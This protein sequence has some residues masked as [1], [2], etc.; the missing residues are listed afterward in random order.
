MRFESGNNE[1]AKDRLPSTTHFIN[2][3]SFVCHGGQVLK[4]TIIKSLLVAIVAVASLGSQSVQAQGG[5]GVVAILDVA[6][7][8]E[9]NLDFKN[10]MEGIRNDAEG[11]KTEITRRQELIK[12]EAQGL[13]KFEVGSANRMTL[14][15]TLKLKQTKLQTFAQQK[16]SLLLNRE[17]RVYYETYRR[18]QGTVESLAAANN[19]SLVLR[20]ESGEINPDNRPEVIKGVNRSVVYHRSAGVDLTS[21]VSKAMN[22]SSAQAQAPA[23]TQYK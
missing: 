22:A 3:I 7:V 5:Q 12:Q 9:Q 19:I 17:A 10:K 16:E 14:E 21:L 6:L 23:Q 4:S 2:Q 8:F 13:G 20:F 18:M 1:Q 15:G 11:L